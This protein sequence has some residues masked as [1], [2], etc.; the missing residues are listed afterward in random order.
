MAGI[1]EGSNPFFRL[2][3]AERQ[4]SHIF[5]ITWGEHEGRLDVSF[6]LPKHLEL[7]RRL[8][9]SPYAVYELGSSVVS[10]QVV[11]GPFGSDLKV[12]EYV[13]QGVP[14]I[15]VSDCCSGFIENNKIV[16]ITEKKHAQLC[17]SEVLPGDVLLTKAGSLGYSAVFPKQLVKGNITSHLASIRPAQGILSRYLSEFLM[18]NAGNQQIHRWGNKSTR[19]ELNTDEVR[20]LLIPVSPKEIQIKLVTAM[21]AARAERRA[22]LAEADA[23]LAGFDSYLLATL[24][25]VLPPKDERKVFAVLQSDFGSQARFD[26]D[27]FHP[28]RILTL[29]AL[30]HSER[31]LDCP[32]LQQ[33]ADFIRHPIK[34]PGPGYLSLSNVQSHTGD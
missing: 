29:R 24:G 34:S 13:P 30:K 27:Y 4:N 9:T 33:V 16:H 2:S 15:R 28:E 32:R 25:L 1:P 26:A 5:G 14:L 19:P 21:D 7:E 6:Y 18:S 12:N 10:K 23:L 20:K 3:P 11:D 22:K 8:K 31:E 17:R